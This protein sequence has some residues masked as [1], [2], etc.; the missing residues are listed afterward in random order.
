MNNFKWNKHVPLP[1]LRKNNFNLPP[2]SGGSRD[3]LRPGFSSLARCERKEPGYEVDARIDLRVV[4]AR[5]SC[6]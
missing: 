5:R 6:R 3:Q 2:E 4:S 1:P